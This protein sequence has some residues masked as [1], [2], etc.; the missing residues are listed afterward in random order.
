MS[1][2]EGLGLNRVPWLLRTLRKR[3]SYIFGRFRAVRAAYSRIQNIRQVFGGPRTLMIGDWAQTPVTPLKVAP[4]DFVTT[5]RSR[6]QHFQEL[7]RNAFST[8]IQLTPDA[9]ENLLSVA[10]HGPL[11]LKGQPVRLLTS[12]DEIDST[13]LRQRAAVVPVHDSIRSDVIK[14]IASDPIIVETVANYLGY[15]PK[16]VRSY[17]SW[18]LVNAMTE[19]ERAPLQTIRFHYDV[20]G[21]NFIYV[22][23]YLVPT[24]AQSGAHV[25]IAGSHRDKRLR[26]LLGS[27]RMAD[28]QALRD[29]GESRIKLIEGAAGTGFFE[30]ASCYH[31]ALT[32]LTQDRLMLQLR[33]Q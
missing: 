18:S 7:A 20:E 4:S 10:K 30:D 27:T 12:Y 3:P 26:H 21:Y 11:R 23:F 2:A 22:S 17:F 16:T 5:T 6:E 31:K 15:F 9:C 19:A 1:A 8:G 25:I 33:Y 13:G 32:P 29:Y 14:G 24:D 28:A